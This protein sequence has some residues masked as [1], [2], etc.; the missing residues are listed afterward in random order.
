MDEADRRESNRIAKITEQI[1]AREAEQQRAARE[2]GARLMGQMPAPAAAAVEGVAPAMPAPQPAMPPPSPVQAEP[3]PDV[4]QRGEAP[5]AVSQG[6]AARAALDPNAPDYAQ[7]IM[8]INDRVIAQTMPGQ[9]MPRPAPAVAPAAPAAPTQ[10]AH[11]TTGRPM[12]PNPD[13]SVSTEESVTVTH[14]RL[15]GGR[16]TN[17]PSIWNGRRFD[18]ETQ[19]DQIVEEALRS[20]QAFPSFN[21]IEEA[22]SAAQARSDALGRVIAQ[23][24]APQ[25]GPITLAPRTGS[26][27]RPTAAAMQQPPG[28]NL[29]ALQEGLASPNPMIRAQA[30]AAL[31]AEQLRRQQSQPGAT[32]QMD[33][34]QGPGVYERLP[35]GGVRRIGG[36]PPQQPDATQRLLER[37]RELTARGDQATPAEVEERGILARRLQ[38]SG[39]NVT[40]NSERSFADRLAGKA[41]D[42]IDTLDE[43]AGQAVQTIERAD[44]IAD[45]LESGVITGTGA[46]ARLAVE[47]LLRTAGMIDGRRVV[48][49]E[50]LM[51]ELATGTLAASGQL[52][53]P[54]S[55]RDILFLREVA[56][57][58][59]DLTPET[60]SRAAT[61]ARAV[62]ERTVTRFNDIA[63]TVQADERLPASVRELYRPRSF[64]TRAPRP[65]PSPTPAQGG[66]WSIQPVP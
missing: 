36:L 42:R 21:S 63:T 40:V 11:P 4:P 37:W 44:R 19:E 18:P 64:P 5:P 60:I 9:A 30:Q 34:P 56:A 10:G 16:P 47:R 14:P 27:P 12:L 25:G 49:T 26:A 41:A 55:D 58:R 65:A 8:A 7:R 32:I 38:G 17:I 57:G 66:G 33:G 59:I 24:P 46:E 6:I 52:S 2:F 35:N 1:A 29:A 15:N 61:V 43:H 28:L 20:G 45:L 53:G 3:L 23:P 62:A 48:N 22:V 39:T 51:T 54:T 50:Q 13:G 31:Q